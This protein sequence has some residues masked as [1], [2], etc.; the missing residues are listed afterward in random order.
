MSATVVAILDG[1]AW[2]FGGLF[3]LIVVIAAVGT[4]IDAHPRPDAE[5][6]DIMRRIDQMTEQ[7][8][9]DMARV[10]ARHG[11]HSSDPDT[12]FDRWMR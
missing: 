8:K 12:T 6:R 3:A 9:A 11:D 7:A 10:A 2:G 1:L 4:Y 5:A